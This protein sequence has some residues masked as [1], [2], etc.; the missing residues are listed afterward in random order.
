MFL[1]KLY[2]PVLLELFIALVK[3]APSLHNSQQSPPGIVIAVANNDLVSNDISNSSNTSQHWLNPPHVLSDLTLHKAKQEF[4]T[5]SFSVKTQ[6]PMRS[7]KANLLN[8]SKTNKSTAFNFTSA[9]SRSFSDHRNLLIGFMS[10][11]FEA[12]FANTTIQNTPIIPSPDVSFSPSDH[13]HNRNHRF[14]IISSLYHF[15]SPS[16]RTF[17][18]LRRFFSNL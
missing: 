13:N 12:S 8:V 17:L 1:H 9:V 3:S 6:T 16:R 18:A 14:S 5:S 11:I 10:R 7:M 2:I 4:D 15:S